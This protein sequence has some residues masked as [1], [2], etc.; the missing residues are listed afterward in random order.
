MIAFAK[1]IGTREGESKY[2]LLAMAV[3]RTVR[4]ADVRFA[5]AGY[6]AD[7]AVSQFGDGR[8]RVERGKKNVFIFHDW[9]DAYGQFVESDYDKAVFLGKFDHPD[10]GKSVTLASYPVARPRVLPTDKEF[11]V[12]ITGDYEIPGICDWILQKLKEVS[13][14]A[15]RIACFNNLP[16]STE[17]TDPAYW[18]L[19]HTVRNFV[20]DND[21]V[22]VVP[23]ASIGLLADYMYACRHILHCGGHRGMV[24]SLAVSTGKCMS[25][26]GDDSFSPASLDD[27]VVRLLPMLR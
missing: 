12:L 5:S 2:D 25:F 19:I 14:S 6:P 17:E 10:I 9:F 22:D 27:L 16:L 26:T 3:A 20:G 7:L 15:V 21:L 1:D 23:N 18:E 13:K 8:A 11:P 4:T 24:H